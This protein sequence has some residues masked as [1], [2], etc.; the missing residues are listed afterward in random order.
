MIFKQL[1]IGYM[2][3]ELIKKKNVYVDRL[4]SLKNLGEPIRNRYTEAE[5]RQLY[6][7]DLMKSIQ[8]IDEAIQIYNT[9]SSD[10]YSH[11]DP[12]DIEKATKI[13]N[14]KQNWYDQTANRF[15]ALKTYEDATITCSQIKQ[16]RDALE[17]ECWAIL[18]KPKPKVEPPK[19]DTTKQQ[20]NN[21][22]QQPEGSPQPPPP[23]GNQ[24][25]QSTEPQPNMEVD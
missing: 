11:I 14:D 1:N 10:K 18:N 13:L 8:R 12:T 20:T 23:S 22:Q 6:M 2:M 9:K 4:K 19:E 17:K 3:K 24:N 15:S 5:N 16:E 7:Q 25:Q 21:Q